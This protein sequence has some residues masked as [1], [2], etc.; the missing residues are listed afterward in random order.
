M[1]YLNTVDGIAGVIALIMLYYLR[2]LFTG[3][4]EDNKFW[5]ATMF[6]SL[7]AALYIWKSGTA[8]KWLMLAREAMRHI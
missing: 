4:A 6:V 5:Y 3:G 1:E 2:K 8:E 7:G